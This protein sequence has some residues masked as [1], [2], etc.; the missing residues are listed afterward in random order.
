VR[1]GASTLRAI[2]DV[3][4]DEVVTVWGVHLRRGLDSVEIG[5]HLEQ[6]TGISVCE[7]EIKKRMKIGKKRK[8]KNKKKERKKE[9]KEDG[10]KKKKK[11]KKNERKSESQRE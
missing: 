11:R 1:S 8:K 3:F 4:C 7:N 10:K 2:V 6:S 5:S 9:E